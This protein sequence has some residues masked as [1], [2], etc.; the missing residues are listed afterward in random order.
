M[1]TWSAR[2]DAPSWPMHAFRDRFLAAFGAGRDVG[3]DGLRA[4]AAQRS[5]GGAAPG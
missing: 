5:V 2:A 4:P 1:S 3:E